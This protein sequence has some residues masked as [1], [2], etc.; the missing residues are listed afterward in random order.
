MLVFLVF[1]IIF[2]VILGIYFSI[3][4]N[5]YGD[6]NLFPISFLLALV[7]TF[8]LA[9]YRNET[10][11]FQKDK[12]VRNEDLKIYSLKTSE[13][14]SF[15]LGSGSIN[16]NYTAFQKVGDGFQKVEISSSAIIK[17]DLNSS[18]GY[19]ESYSCEPGERS[20]YLFLSKTTKDWCDI[21][22]DKP[23]TVHVPKG[24][25]MLNFKVE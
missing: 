5:I 21:S 19:V 12:I 16:E 1:F 11:N 4:S 9:Y 6:E 25:V 20:S 24:T 10:T 3:K 2:V 14:G 7:C 22:V 18:E 8:I 13:G 23:I 15:I 17:E